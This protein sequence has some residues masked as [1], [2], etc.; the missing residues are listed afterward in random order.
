MQ[1]KSSTQTVV[2][3]AYRPK[4]LQPMQTV[5][6]AELTLEQ[7]LV[8]DARGRPGNRQVTLLAASDWQTVCRELGAQLPWT[9]RRSNI[10][11]DGEWDWPSLSGRHL[12]VGEALLELTIEIDPCSRMDAQQP[13]LTGALTPN[14]RGGI[15]ASVIEA[16]PVAVGSPVQLLGAE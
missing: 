5:A 4:P 16:G 9:L 12:R 13:G 11:L 10:L 3:L 1:S 2:G 7:G 14:W 8:G 6:A 15:G